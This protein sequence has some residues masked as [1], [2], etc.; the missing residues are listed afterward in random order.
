MDHELI[1]AQADVDDLI[2][3]IHQL[4]DDEAPAPEA[5][6]PVPEAEEAPEAKAA[7]M[8]EEAPAA[9]EPPV[10][11]VPAEEQQPHH[12]TDRQKV[13]KHVAKLQNNQQEAY[14]RWLQ[15]QEEKGEEP[16]PVFEEE[17]P[18]RKKKRDR[19]AAPDNAQP[20]IAVA[21]KPKKS[22]F[23]VWFS[24]LLVLLT[25]LTAVVTVLFVPRRP[26]AQN[27]LL[28][29]D[30]AASVLL[31]GTDESLG[32]TDMLML[33]TVNS[34]KR[35]VSL[36][37]IPRDTAVL[38]EEGILSIGSVYGLAGGGSAGMEALKEAVRGCVGFEPDGCLI[39]YPQALLDFMDVL[40]AELTGE[41]AYEL[42]RADGETAQADLTRVQTQRNF[43]VDV[44]CRCQS[45]SAVLKA[46][47]LLEVLSRS[48]VTDLDTGNLLWL[49][50]TAFLA[51]C[52]NTEQ[53]TLPGTA[54]EDDAYFLDP[55]LIVQNIN[56]YCNPYVRAVSAD[57]LQLVQRPEEA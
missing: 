53:T 28:H 25:L 22:R 7:E 14:A 38:T 35:T 11:E 55:Q 13:P 39:L 17:L 43:L 50:R 6:S 54:R 16:P 26:L 12:W 36:V 20:E 10:T 18:K 9:E 15:E 49:A 5:P 56:A 31:A 4:I 32:R 48:A 23:A 41:E 45:F 2:S 29:S 24:I 47:R 40:D 30:G 42:L 57:D 27:D 19:D 44:M 34:A 21:V 1:Q 51:D 46:P 3:D 8:P 37:S 52:A 33:M